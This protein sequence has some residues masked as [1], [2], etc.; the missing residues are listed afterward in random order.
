VIVRWLRKR[1][2]VECVEE[3]RID[4]DSEER[5]KEGLAGYTCILA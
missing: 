2:I 4:E 3:K 1:G 5:D